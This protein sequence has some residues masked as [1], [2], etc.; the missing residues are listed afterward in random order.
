ARYTTNGSLDTFF[1]T[2]GQVTTDF[3][4]R[5]VARALAIQGD[6]QIV[7][8]GDTCSST[9]TDCNFA[10]ARYTTNVS[11]DTFFGTAGQVTTD[12]GG[13]DVAHA[14]AI[15]GNGQIVVAGDTCNSTFT[16][17]NFALASYKP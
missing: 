1:G 9:S 10:L 13:R 2:A 17:C 14:L 3:G 4:G 5:D 12:F 8:A 16:D 11:L 7:V 15:Q 6:G